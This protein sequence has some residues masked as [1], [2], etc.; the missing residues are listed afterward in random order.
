V[1][2]VFPYA[3][4]YWGFYAGGVDLMGDFYL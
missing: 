4:N 1:G 2:A 3:T